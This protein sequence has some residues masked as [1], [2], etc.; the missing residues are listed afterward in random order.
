M[1]RSH[2]E[3]HDDEPD[4]RPAHDVL[5]VPDYPEWST[6]SGLMRNRGGVVVT[7]C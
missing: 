4:E 3:A 6:R 1:D 7:P 5:Y 2:I